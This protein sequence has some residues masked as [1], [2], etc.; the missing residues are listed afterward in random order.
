MHPNYGLCSCCTPRPGSLSPQGSSTPGRSLSL[1]ASAPF[2]QLFLFPLTKDAW[3]VPG[4]TSHRG[5]FDTGSERRA[6]SSGFLALGTA[7]LDTGVNYLLGGCAAFEQ[8]IRINRTKDLSCFDFGIKIIQLPLL[9]QNIL[10]LTLP[11]DKE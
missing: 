5:G 7:T 6:R 9:L 4:S 8:L 1:P 11:S 3:C 10:L 2:L